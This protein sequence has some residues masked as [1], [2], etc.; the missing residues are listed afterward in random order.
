MKQER[1]GNTHWADRDD[2]NTQRITVKE[3]GFW[4]LTLDVSHPSSLRKAV[5]RLPLLKVTLLKCLC[6]FS[7]QPKFILTEM[8]FSY[9]FFVSKK[10]GEGV[11]KS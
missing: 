9:T 10:S 5:V 8:S 11:M 4:T 6:S 1:H 3:G 7:R 2:S